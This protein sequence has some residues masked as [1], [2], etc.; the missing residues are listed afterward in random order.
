VTVRDRS[1]QLLA[2]PLGPE[3]LLLLLARGAEAAAAAGEGDE[4]A[5]AAIGAPQP[6][7]AVSWD[8]APDEPPQHALDGGP[9]RAVFLGEALVV[10]AEELVD[11]LADKTEQS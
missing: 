10:H 5:P 11:V 4:N 6:G 8:A 2:Q 3:E 1:E 9:Q 7:E